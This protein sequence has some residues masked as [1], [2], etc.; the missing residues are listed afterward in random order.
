MYKIFVV[1][2]E[3]LIRQSLRTAI[4]TS[5]GPYMFCGEAGDGEMALS[6]MMDLQPDILI[7]DIKM[8]F[9]D[10]LELARLAGESMPWLKTIIVSGHDEFGYAQQAISI[11]VDQYL[12][13]PIRQAELIKAVETAV[14]GIDAEKKRAERASRYDDH[15]VE[16]ALFRQLMHHVLF[17][18][19]PAARILDD[20]KSLGVNLMHPFHQVVLVELSGAAAGEDER[21]AARDALLN[22]LGRDIATPG[23]FVMPDQLVFVASA[24]TEQALSEE[25][26]T[27]LRVVLHEL[28]AY[29]VQAVTIVSTPAERLSAVS[30]A[31]SRVSSMARLA[32]HLYAGQIVDLSDRSQAPAVPSTCTGTFSASCAKKLQYATAEDASDMLDEFLGT[33]DDVI[34]GSQIGRYQILLDIYSTCAGVI[35]EDGSESAAAAALGGVLDLVDGSAAREAFHACA[36]ELVDRTVTARR[37]SGDVTTR[38]GIMQ[39]AVEFIEENYNNPDISLHLVSAH[40][41]F[42]PAHFSM[43]FS[44]K[45]GRTFIDYLTG[46]RIDKARELLSSTDKKL[47]AIAAEVGYNEP[48]Y[49]SYVFKKRVG[50]TPKEYRNRQQHPEAAHA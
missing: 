28:E 16:A 27:T 11:G 19:A 44:Q 43:M 42:S 13:K 22:R 8:P 30:D 20:A 4:E 34:L 46:V 45:M 6:M 2:D 37:K 10:G 36:H 39:Q 32:G 29:G 14:A 17:G 21:R 40:V 33:L 5:S 38:G 3:P 31:Y 47:S 15:E 1:E 48:N 9:M 35:Q 23:I 12:L 41:G 25:T 7:T 26:Y 50:V 18:D 24:D 49:F